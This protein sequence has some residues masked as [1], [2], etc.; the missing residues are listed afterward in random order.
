M[1][2]FLGYDDEDALP[3]AV[4]L[5]IAIQLT[6]ILRD[7]GEDAA[8]GRIYLPAEDLARFRYSNDALCGRALTPAFAALME[9]QIARAER[10]YQ[11]GLRGVLLLNK[12][13]RLA[14][15]LSVTL[16]Q[17]ILHRIRR[18]H[19]DV[20]GARAHVSLPAKLCALPRVWLRTRRR[21]V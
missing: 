5:G 20:F 14:I 8:R 3:Y 7:I 16:Y 13:A 18:N 6:N 9:F 21:Q 11:R 17:G 19:Y 10:F 2:P 15:A 1:A 12:D 4:D